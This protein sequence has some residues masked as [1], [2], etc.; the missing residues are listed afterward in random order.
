MRDVQHYLSWLDVDNQIHTVELLQG[1]KEIL[2]GRSPDMDIEIFNR[3]ISRRHVKASWKAGKLTLTDLNSSYGTWVNN[4]RLTSAEPFV[5]PMDAEIRLGNMNIWYELHS[6]NDDTWHTS[7]VADDD[8]CDKPL[9]PEM[10]EF[11]DDIDRLLA[12]ESVSEQSKNQITQLL[13]KLNTSQQQRLHE[14]ELLHSVSHVLNRSLNFSE[15]SRVALEFIMQATQAQRGMLLL[16]DEQQCFKTGAAIGLNLSQQ[17]ALQE[18]HLALFQQVLAQNH[19]QVVNDNQ[20]EAKDQDGV[21]CFAIIPLLQ[22]QNLCGVVYLDHTVSK[23]LFPPQQR[24]FLRTFAAHLS[25][26]MHNTELFQKATTDDLTQL[27]TRSY[28]EEVLN[29]EM[30]RA[31]RTNSEFSVLFL[32][33]DWFKRI[34]DNHGHE[35]GDKALL[36]FAALLQREIREYDSACRYGGEEFLLVLPQINQ[37]MALQCA[38]RIRLATEKLD[39]P[40]GKDVVKLTTSIGVASY[41]STADGSGSYANYQELLKAAD[42]ALYAAKRAGRNQ[43]QSAG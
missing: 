9:L 42:M 4:Q 8:A 22:Q 38:E 5:V 24:P 14:Q 32:D 27:Y 34:N 6:P 37:E 41:A 2:I 16:M 39:I 11:S 28:V 10:A 12:K 31:S 13:A 3:S 36:E 17:N 20:R 25:I 1:Q 19:I 35:V 18:Q 15:L 21:K 33:L 29:I 26:A 40:C 30:N 23:Q 7:F 43:V